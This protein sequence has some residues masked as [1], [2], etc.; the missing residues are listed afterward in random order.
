MRRRGRRIRRRR[1]ST[2]YNWGILAWKERRMRRDNIGAENEAQNICN[3]LRSFY[4]RPVRS[5][6]LNTPMF[7]IFSHDISWRVLQMSDY[8]HDFSTTLMIHNFWKAREY[9][10]FK[11]IVPDFR[12]MLS[13]SSRNS[14]FMNFDVLFN[15]WP[16]PNP[17]PCHGQ[18][19]LF[20]RG[21]LMGKPIIILQSPL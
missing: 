14:L 9:W 1:R 10:A 15:H 4:I 8:V 19:H 16:I 3:R 21:G 11:E 20:R 13:D 7:S 6:E 12:W 5:T 2:E 17:Q 18:G